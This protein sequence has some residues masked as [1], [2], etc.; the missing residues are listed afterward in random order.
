[1]KKPVT[2]QKK[3]KF[4]Y[5]V[6]VA[7][8]LTH[9]PEDF[10]TEVEAFKQKLKSICNVPSFWGLKPGDPYEVYL[11]DIH[12]CVRK[13][14]LMVAICDFPA[15]G[16][17]YEIATQVEARRMPCLAIAHNKSLV[18]DLILDTKQPGYEFRR[19]KDL[20]TDALDMVI[21]R[22]EKMRQ[23]DKIKKLKRLPAKVK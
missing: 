9:A 23:G 17:G 7:C 15:T 4:D 18:T 5:N 2:K 22:L 19:Y 11:W 20:Q 10:R 12:D 1:M 21:E 8:S 6:Y 13:S 16:L 14:D 3:P